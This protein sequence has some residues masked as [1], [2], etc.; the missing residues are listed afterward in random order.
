MRRSLWRAH[1]PR[2]GLYF[3]LA[4]G[5]AA[6]PLG[7]VLYLYLLAPYVLL[8]YLCVLNYVLADA[9]L[10]LGHGALVDNDL[11]LCYGHNDLI[12]AYVGFGSL[13]FYG[14]PLDRDFLVAGGG[15]YVVPGRAFALV[16][17]PGEGLALR[18]AFGH[19]LLSLLH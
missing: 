10:F 6:A 8:D 15:P 14:H 18:G 4:L 11:F 1:P 3:L 7:C 9:H 16:E 5:R 17:P 13:P 12:L 2:G 19:A